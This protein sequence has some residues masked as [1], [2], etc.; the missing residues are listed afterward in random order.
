MIA[1]VEHI[2]EADFKSTGLKRDQPESYYAEPV[3]WPEDDDDWDWTDVRY[4]VLKNKLHHVPNVVLKPP[5]SLMLQSLLQSL[6]ESR[7][8]SHGERYPQGP[9]V[10]LRRM[11]PWGEEQPSPV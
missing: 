9:V 11:P 7:V 4:F 6:S 1:Q 3:P 8:P 10:F 5:R 2:I